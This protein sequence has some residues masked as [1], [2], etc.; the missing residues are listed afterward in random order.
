MGRHSS[1]HDRLAAGEYVPVEELV[2]ESV[3]LPETKPQP[4]ARARRSRHRA[5]DDA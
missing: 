1:A 3:V 4:I 5:E 2:Q